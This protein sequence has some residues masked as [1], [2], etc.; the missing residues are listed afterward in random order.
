MTHNES[1][2]A[3]CDERL[4]LI[5]AEGVAA[6]GDVGVGYSLL[7]RAL[8]Q[9]EQE[10]AAGSPSAGDQLRLWREE[11][12]RFKREYRIDTSDEGAAH[13]GRRGSAAS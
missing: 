7:V 10:D 4:L 1:R 2:A 5:E 3:S 8:R 12:D 9:T 13:S 6:L 11:L